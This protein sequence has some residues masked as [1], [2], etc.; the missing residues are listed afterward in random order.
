[1]AIGHGKTMTIFHI[2]GGVFWTFC[3]RWTGKNLKTR[4]FALQAIGIL[5][6]SNKAE[7]L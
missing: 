6:A 7:S 4:L 3:D 5:F 2:P 1:M